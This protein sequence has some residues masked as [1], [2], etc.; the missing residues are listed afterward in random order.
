MLVLLA[1]LGLLAGSLPAYAAPRTVVALGDSFASGVGSFVYYDDD[2]DCYRSPFAYSSLLAGATGLP[3]TLAACSGAT[4]TDVHQQQVGYLS[5]STSYVTITVGGND[6]GFRN[7][8]T[9]CALPGW[10]GNCDAAVDAG[11]RTL[12]SVL[13]DRLDAL[14][15]EVET[16]APNATVAVTG[17]PLLFNGTDCNPLTFFTAAEMSRINDGTVELNTLIRN[18]AHRAGFRY[19][20][21]AP[22]F[23]GH[24]TCDAQPWVNNLVYP[25]VNSFHQNVAGHYAYAVL[26]APALFGTSVARS[27]ARPLPESR[28]RLPEVRSAAGPTRLRLPDLNSPAV[29]RAAARAGVTRAEL[30]Q[31]RAAQ[32]S[33]TS[34]IALD[35][36]DARITAAAQRR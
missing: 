11:L 15:A 31:L 6:V 16:R 9:T 4:T 32:R 10:L 18:R 36:L 33:G 7:V 27:D 20:A 8:V 28:V 34:N 26:T 19:V 12:R 29:T 1:A 2:T 13:A 21:A 22:A 17:Y 14:Y 3:L 23:V 25:T 24:A 30:R 35:R 5:S